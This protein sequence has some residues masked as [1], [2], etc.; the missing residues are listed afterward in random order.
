M[1]T[2]FRFHQKR[3]VGYRAEE[4]IMAGGAFVR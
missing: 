3:A 1:I 2:H 4:M